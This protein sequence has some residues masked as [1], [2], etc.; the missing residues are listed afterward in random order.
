MTMVCI[1]MGD[2]DMRDEGLWIQLFVNLR[3]H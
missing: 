1:T 3:V 2:D